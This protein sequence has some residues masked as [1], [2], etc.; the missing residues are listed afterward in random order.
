LPD[1]ENASAHL[2]ML[3]YAADALFQIDERAISAING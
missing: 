2:V 3:P 1:N